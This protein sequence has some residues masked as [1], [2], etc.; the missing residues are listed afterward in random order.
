MITK[1]NDSEILQDNRE[2]ILASL[3]VAVSTPVKAIR[4]LRVGHAKERPLRAPGGTKCGAL[5][6]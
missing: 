5:A 1:R 3:N 4:G 6:C 2:K